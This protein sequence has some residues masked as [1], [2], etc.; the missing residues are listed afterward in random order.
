MIIDVVI[1]FMKTQPKGRSMSEL[2]KAAK[3]HP[4]LRHFHPTFV[5]A[6]IEVWQEEHDTDEQETTRTTEGLG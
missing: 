5:E 3:D 4:V 6:A 2:L 1:K